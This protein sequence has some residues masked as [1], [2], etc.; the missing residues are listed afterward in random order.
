MLVLPHTTSSSKSISKWG[1]AVRQT[2]AAATS[3]TSCWE[4]DNDKEKIIRLILMHWLKGST[5]LASDQR[6][7]Y[8]SRNGVSLHTQCPKDLQSI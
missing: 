6:N 4:Q 1:W 5:T 7:V 8:H 3:I 2:Y